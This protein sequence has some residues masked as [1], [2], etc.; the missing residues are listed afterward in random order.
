MVQ[1]NRDRSAATGDIRIVLRKHKKPRDGRCFPQPDQITGSAPDA[2]IL[3]VP[4]PAVV[5]C[6]EA[7]EIRHL[8]G[9]HVS[10]IL[11]HGRNRV[12]PMKRLS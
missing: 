6:H 9:T 4:I 2:T 10:H 7:Q 1:E 3:V 12:A 5:V 11:Y 8:G